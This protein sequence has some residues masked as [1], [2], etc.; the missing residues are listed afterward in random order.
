MPLDPTLV[1]ALEQELAYAKQLKPGGQP[2][3]EGRIAAIQEQ[4]RLHSGGE[5]PEAE[6]SDASNQSTDYASTD[7]VHEARAAKDRAKRGAKETAVAT[8]PTDSADAQTADETPDADVALET[9]DAA[10]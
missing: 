3:D 1:P 8:R 5:L 6:A 2:V 7:N 4:I 9:A 10:E